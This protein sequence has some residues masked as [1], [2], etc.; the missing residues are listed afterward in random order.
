[1][2]EILV[3]VH[4]GSACGS[5]DFNLGVFSAENA[6]DDLMGAIEAWNGPVVVVDGELSDELPRYRL[7]DEA[8]LKA[9]ARAGANGARVMAC[10]S[11]GETHLAAE[12][13]I[14]VLGLDPAKDRVVVTGCWFDPSG[15]SG[16]VN[17]VEKDFLARGFGARIDL[18]AVAVSNSSVETAVS[19]W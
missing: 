14:K 6:R 15:S 17:A 11:W 19:P 16:C 4:P 3:I 5:A 2:R 18:S 13:A 8:I 1:M 12:R 10:D 9:L 7:L